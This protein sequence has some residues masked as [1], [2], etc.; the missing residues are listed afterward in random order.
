MP[1]PFR[2]DRLLPGLVGV[3]LSN[4][5]RLRALETGAHPTRR[6]DE[7]DT[8]PWMDLDLLGNWS[9]DATDPPQWRMRSGT[10]QLRGVATNSIDWIGGTEQDV[11][12]LD[13]AAYPSATLRLRAMD[14]DD[15]D[16]LAT[17]GVDGLLKAQPGGTASEDLRLDS[18]AWP[19]G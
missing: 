3:N 11:A 4:E 14:G 7:G 17:V 12:A 15:E 2:A 18:L 19:E 1:V 16:V 13:S 8:T 5:H 10:V 6:V 9:P